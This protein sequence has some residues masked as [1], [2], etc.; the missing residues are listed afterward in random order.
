MSNPE[1]KKLK[2]RTELYKNA[3]PRY[4]KSDAQPFIKRKK[5]N[6]RKKLRGNEICPYCGKR[7]STYTAT[8]D[9]IVPLSRGGTDDRENLI[10]CCKK[11]NLEK[12]SMLLSEWFEYKFTDTHTDTVTDT[13]E[14]E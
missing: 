1:V 12:G 8:T 6:T 4:K 14:E 2:V 3:H 13:Q 10:L 9:H 5:M 7:L 11:C